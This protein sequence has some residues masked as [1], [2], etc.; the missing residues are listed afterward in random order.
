MSVFLH[1]DPSIMERDLIVKTYSWFLF[2][3]VPVE[4]ESLPNSVCVSC[5]CVIVAFKKSFKLCV[6]PNLSRIIKYKNSCVWCDEKPHM[7]TSSRSRGNALARM[8]EPSQWKDLK[9]IYESHALP[10]FFPKAKEAS[11][12]LESKQRKWLLAGQV[13][14][15][16]V[17]RCSRMLLNKLTPA[18]TIGLLFPTHWTITMFK[19]SFLIWNTQRFHFNI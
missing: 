10:A 11:Y 4:S 6:Q 13:S 12:K 5:E 19:Q 8:N 7:N 18:E 3:I 17:F 9:E 2:P 1:D 16:K 14:P 15:G